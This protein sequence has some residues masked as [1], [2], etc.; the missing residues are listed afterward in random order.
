MLSTMMRGAV[1]AATA[2]LAVNAASAEAKPLSR[3]GA[4]DDDGVVAGGGQGRLRDLFSPVK[5]VVAVTGPVTLDAL[6]L[7]EPL[8]LDIEESGSLTVLGDF[9][10][11]QG[12]INVDGVLTG[13]EAVLLGGLLTGSGMIDPTYLI[14]VHTTIAPGGIGELGTLTVKGDLILSSVATLFVEASR[15]GGDRLSVV[16]DE[17]QPGVASLGGTLLFTKG[18]GAPPRH[19]QTFDIVTAT[20]GVTGAFD[21]VVSL[22][23]V[24]RPELTY[25][26]N[27]VTAQLRAGKLVDL[28]SDA[29]EAARL[30][31]AALDSVRGSSYA[32]LHNLYGEIDLMDGATLAAT[33]DG[34]AP[35]AAFEAD[36]LQDMQD[37]LV[38]SAVGDRLSGLG[39]DGASGLTFVGAPEAVL[40]LNGDRGLANGS[41]GVSAFVSG[42]YAAD[43][44]SALTGRPAADS[45]RLQAWHLTVGVEK[46]VASG[47]TLGAAVGYA[48]GD[49]GRR[50]LASRADGRTTQTAVYGAY[51]FGGAYIAGLAA[52]GSTR[53]DTERRPTAGLVDY[54]L[55]GEA[56]ARSY[57]LAA[58]A[59][60][61][62]AHP[63]ARAALRRHRVQRLPRAR[64]RRRAPGR[65]PRLQP[66]REPRRPEAR[67]P[68]HGARRLVARAAA[69]GRLCPQPVRR[70]EGP[71]GRLRRGAG[72]RLHPARRRPRPVVGRGQG[73]RQPA[74]RPGRLRPVDAD[75]PRPRGAAREP[76]AGER[77]ARLLAQ[78]SLSSCGRGT[79]AQR[80]GAGAALASAAGPPL[81]N[82]EG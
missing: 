5:K 42:G 41:D 14:A 16:G 70:R 28:L 22:V 34:L 13:R 8:L 44:G 51:R 27:K 18:R 4:G 20:G 36:A 40:L 12:W 62:F 6:N 2:A 30:F 49:S 31:A 9:I 32:N 66:R 61:N 45:G 3:S 50:N 1:L 24:L 56:E 29:G 72:L 69:F 35:T 81:P 68:R 25:G 37:S 23:G 15:A 64:R 21:K 11:S 59:G 39:A 19:G 10:Q 26:P 17:T 71:D 75:Q 47:L 65:G 74:Q 53:A 73:R 63:A 54:R 55:T 38:L 48:S 76:R 33:L 43:G 57:N 67:G 46:Q 60:Y 80:Q 79:G 52:A 77:R 7:D 82:G 58:E 78:S